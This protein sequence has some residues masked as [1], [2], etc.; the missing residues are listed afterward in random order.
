MEDKQESKLKGSWFVQR[1]LNNHMVTRLLIILLILLIL[2]VFT[3]VSYLFTPLQVVFEVAA[4]PI[5]VSGVMFYLLVP[6]VERMEQRGINRPIAIAIIFV[7][8][9]LLLTW[10]V[11]SLI[12]TL[13][14][15]ILGFIASMPTYVNEINRMI[16]ELPYVTENDQIANVLQKSMIDLDWKSISEQLNKIVQTTFGSLGNVVG[17]ITQVV[18]GL[19]TVPIVLYYLLADGSKIGPKLL[20]YV[21]TRYQEMA[22]RM[23][24]QGHYQVSQYIRGQIVVAI[25]VAI[26]FTI[27]YSIVGLDY[28]IAL[29]VLSGFL[30][31]I[32]YLGSFIAVV[33][34]L[35]IALITSP[36]MVVKVII[37]MMIEQTIE[38]RFIA[39]QVL[40]NNL[41]IH[42]VTILIVLL[43]AGKAF[44]LIGVILGVPGYAVMK[45]IVTEL[46]NLYRENS[47]KYEPIKEAN[48]EG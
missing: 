44:G 32:P 22:K 14:Q 45:V 40:G 5:I 33:P 17:T 10:G 43:A 6:L 8:L 24:Y 2:L 37:V 41:K 28:A 27:G 29:G 38:G 26:M 19:L 15:Q 9:L 46:Y 30:N 1:F 39:P 25:C 4:F 42:P 11:A 16:N 7:G 13:Q 21:P 12:P 18:M 47:D 31:I 34:A 20:Y 36:V 48:H 35:I 3:K 23:M